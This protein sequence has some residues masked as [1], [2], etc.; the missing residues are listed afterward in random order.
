M[1]HTF[2]AT[3]E[4]QD[5]AQRLMDD[6]HAAGYAHAELERSGATHSG[7][8]TRQRHAVVLSVDSESEAS[9]A[10]GIIEC[11]K[12][13]R[14]QVER[15]E[16]VDS[17][18]AGTPAKDRMVLAYPAGAEPGILQFRPLDDGHIFGTQSATSPPT[19]TTY[20]EKMS[21]ATLQT[22]ADAFLGLS[23]VTTKWTGIGLDT[24]VNEHTAYRFGGDLHMSDR[25]R[26][27]SW[28][29]AEPSLKSEWSARS[30]DSPTWENAKSSV[31]RGWDETT[32]DIDDDDYYR[33]HWTTS[34]ARNTVGRGGD[35]ATPAYMDDGA[36]RAGEEYPSRATGSTRQLSSW[37]RFED[38]VLHGWKRIN[39][40]GRDP[41]RASDTGASDEAYRAS[42]AYGEAAGLDPAAGTWDDKAHV[43]RRIS[44]WKKVRDS[45]HQGWKRVRA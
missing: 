11:T 8:Y 31:R 1:R 9:L 40:T 4:H 14:F 25:Y 29:E 5:D 17:T 22:G 13:A 6:L 43:E 28:N 44:P 2:K 27:R 39:L 23:S 26:N 36:V 32:P 16:S 3:F 7:P 41:G 20:Q 38:A 37:E 42:A 35:D 33:S 12:P 30:T 15:N 45:M 19:G 24:D 21:T 34:Y 10:A 18:T